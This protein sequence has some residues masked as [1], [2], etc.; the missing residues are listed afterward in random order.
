MLYRLAFDE[1]VGVGSGTA[2]VRKLCTSNEKTN[3]KHSE[4]SYVGG[5][6]EDGIASARK[7]C[8]SYGK[9]NQQKRVQA[10]SELACSYG[11]CPNKTRLQHSFLWVGFC[12]LLGTPR[13]EA[14]SGG[15]GG[16]GGHPSNLYFPN[17]PL[18]HGSLRALAHSLSW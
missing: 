13:R 9:T 18:P 14:G 3:H 8:M 1:E 6:G 4:C 7:L 12:A 2:S 16:R 11:S 17:P 10:P 5:E 15:D